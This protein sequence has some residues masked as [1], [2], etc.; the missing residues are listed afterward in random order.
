MYMSEKHTPPSVQDKNDSVAVAAV[1]VVDSSWESFVK[2]VFKLRNEPENV[3]QFSGIFNTLVTRDGNGS[4]SS[5][6]GGSSCLL[7]ILP[8]CLSY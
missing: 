7:I 1:A 3:C 4:K 8:L 5:C 2:V 6:F